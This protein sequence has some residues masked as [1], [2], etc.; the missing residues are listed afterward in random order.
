MT[1]VRTGTAADAGIDAAPAPDA[2]PLIGPL[3]LTMYSTGTPVAFADVV[4]GAADGKMVASGQTNVAGV[5]SYPEFQEGMMVTA[6]VQGATVSVATIVT[7]L[8][9]GTLVLGDPSTNTLRTPIVVNLPSYGQATSYEVDNGCSRNPSTDLVFTLPTRDACISAANQVRVVAYALN[10][11]NQRI[12]YSVTDSSYPPAGDI[13]AGAWKTDLSSV[14]I[15]PSDIPATGSATVTFTARRSAVPRAIYASDALAL[16]GTTLQTLRFAP[17]AFDMGTTTY[18]HDDVVQPLELVR[19]LFRG[20]VLGASGD[21]S[22][23]VSFAQDFLG[24]PLMPMLDRT[25]AARPIVTFG[26]PAPTY[27]MTTV[28]LA[29]VRSRD[30]VTGYVVQMFVPPGRSSV[31]YPELPPA[32]SAVIPVTGD[33]FAAPLV[34]FLA[35]DTLAGYRTV[36]SRPNFNALGGGAPPAFGTAYT[37]RH[38]LAEAAP[39]I[40]PA[41]PR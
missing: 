31:Q 23:T 35:V 28:V 33:T 20:H 37:T 36:V 13:Q 38:S 10:A 27:D 29:I 26:T 19:R 24:L 39:S 4:I 3:T 34:S 5:Y 1:C 21:I 12:A 15:S 8:A 30:P 22:E 41:K 17:G 11:A 6:V 18:L 14:A 32:L 2:A 9:P 40:G 25:T 7:D 16:T